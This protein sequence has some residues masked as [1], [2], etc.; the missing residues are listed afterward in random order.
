MFCVIKAREE[1]DGKDLEGK[2]ISIN[3]AEPLH[4]R[5]KRERRKDSKKANSKK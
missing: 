5:K 1:L 4:K 2:P 3:L